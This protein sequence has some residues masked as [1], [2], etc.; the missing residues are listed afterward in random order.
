MRQSER[1]KRTYLII[2]LCAVLVVMVVGFAAFSSQ[3]QING[4]S[5]IS[6]NWDVKI[7]GITRFASS[8]SG[9][10]DVTGSPSYDNSNGLTAT[11]NTNLTS[12]GDYA[13]YKIK[14]ENLGSLNAKLSKIT[15]NADTSDDIT[16]YV[17]KNQ[18]NSAITDTDRL[19]GENDVLKPTGDSSNLDEGYVYVTVKYNN[20]EG[21]SS[22][23]GSNK[24][25]SAT[26]KIDFVQSNSEAIQQG[27]SRT[28]DSTYIPQYYEYHTENYVTIGQTADTTNWVQDSTELTGK[29]YFLGH[30]VDSTTGNVTANYACFVIDDTQYCMKASSDGSTFSSNKGLLE[31]LKDAGKI[32]C[33]SFDDS[34]AICNEGDTVF[35]SEDLDAGLNGDSLGH[36]VVSSD[37]GASAGSSYNVYCDIYYNDAACYEQ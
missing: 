21:Q 5:N 15:L 20:Y 6:S 30:D 12:P 23:T 10:S 37:G 19:I 18:N 32:S 8:G 4:T 33:S 27:T 11:F 29:N 17:N 36:L 25:V 13:I 35:D 14:I 28:I 3:L 26:V 22:P 9:V 1:D 16:Y 24:S 2:G 34:Y 31:T 7:T